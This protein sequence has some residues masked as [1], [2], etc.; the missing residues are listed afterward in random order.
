MKLYTKV[1]CK[2]EGNTVGGESCWGFPGRSLLPG[3]CCREE[4][5]SGLRKGL[6]SWKASLV[7]L[8]SLTV[9]QPSQHKPYWEGFGS[10][11]FQ[12]LPRQRASVWVTP[13]PRCYVQPTHPHI[14][15]PWDSTTKESNSFP[16]LHRIPT[17][18]SKALDNE[19][20]GF[21]TPNKHHC[22]NHSLQRTLAK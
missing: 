8:L 21:I 20:H 16:H 1:F 4:T 15:L 2:V 10:L 18:G 5:W 14:I 22:S 9:R 19:R 11:P 7:P 12:H 6:R 3:S 17:R 13:H